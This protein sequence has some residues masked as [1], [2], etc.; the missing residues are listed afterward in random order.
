[1]EIMITVISV[2][3]KPLCILCLHVHVVLSTKALH[4]GERIEHCSAL[5]SCRAP[6]L[7]CFLICFKVLA[8][9]IGRQEPA[10]W[11]CRNL[12]D[13]GYFIALHQQLHT[14]QM[15]VLHC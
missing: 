8:M 7:S 11:E 12:W 15:L 10:E 14:L 4:L 3:C 2:Y 6:V 5:L 1:M 9:S 13:E